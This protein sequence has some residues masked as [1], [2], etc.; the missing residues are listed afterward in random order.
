MFS[1]PLVVFRHVD[2]GSKKGG[3]GELRAR[4]SNLE[5]GEFG[6]S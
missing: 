3:G 1:R 4:F 6:G 5:W 2:R